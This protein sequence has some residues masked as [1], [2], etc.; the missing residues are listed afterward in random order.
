MRKAF[1]ARRIPGT[2][3]PANRKPQCRDCKSDKHIVKYMGRWVCGV[4]LKVRNTKIKTG[5]L[6]EQIVLPDAID[7][8]FERR[9]EWSFN[10]LFVNR[11][12]RRSG[13]KTRAFA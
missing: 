11:A 13:G 10:E 12:H 7:L 5:P 4:H 1:R 2:S 9:P 8:P 6:G 3:V